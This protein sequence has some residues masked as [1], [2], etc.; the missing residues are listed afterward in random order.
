MITEDEA[1]EYGRKFA[2][3][4]RPNAAY[5]D[6]EFRALVDPLS[7]EDQERMK[8]AWQRGWAMKSVEMEGEN[9]PYY[10]MVYGCDDCPFR[11]TLG[12]SEYCTHE[13]A[14]REIDTGSIPTWCPLRSTVKTTVKLWEMPEW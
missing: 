7:R 13:G 11:K 4:G 9:G 5:F 10:L 2:E 3:A 1:K 6:E 8:N 14:K 12:L